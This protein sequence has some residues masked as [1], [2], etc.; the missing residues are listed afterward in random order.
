MVIKLL[1]IKIFLKISL[2]KKCSNAGNF[3]IDDIGVCDIDDHNK[4]RYVS[5][6]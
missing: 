6:I 5:V 3:L 2:L 4:S 1:V